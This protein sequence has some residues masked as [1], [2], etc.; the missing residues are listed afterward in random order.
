MAAFALLGLD[1]HGCGLDELGRVAAALRSPAAPLVAIRAATGADEAAL[2]STCNRIEI[3][4]AGAA[5]PA[6]ALLLAGARALAPAAWTVRRDQAARRHLLRVACS[7]ESAAIG[8]AQ[9]QGQVRDARN[10]AHALGSA[11]PLLLAAFDLALCV[12]K[13][14]RRETDLA[15]CGLDLPHRAVAHLRRAA[16]PTPARPIAL[17]GTGALAAA[18]L[19]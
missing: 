9:I 4:L 14:V 19:A 2:L 3:L 16:P 17:L 5:L 15:R 7:L 6:D 18:V 10:T 13:K 12:G 8:E 11:G 1:R